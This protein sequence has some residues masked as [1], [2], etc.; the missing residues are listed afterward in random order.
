MD[1]GNADSTYVDSSSLLKQD[2]MTDITILRNFDETINLG[3]HP[4]TGADMYPHRSVKLTYRVDCGKGAIA[5]SEWKMY[6]GNLGNGEVV[7]A[8][9]SWGKLTYTAANDDETRSVLRST[10]GTKT[11]MR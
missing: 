2:G 10:C 5:I 8:D 11:V 1:G 9:K 4:D 7:W 6:A 3:N